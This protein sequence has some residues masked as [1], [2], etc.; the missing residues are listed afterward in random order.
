MSDDNVI[1]QDGATACRL[2][3]PYSRIRLP[4]YYSLFPRPVDRKSNA[5]PVRYRATPERKVSKKYAMAFRHRGLRST[6]QKGQMSRSH[7]NK[8]LKSVWV[9]STALHHRAL[10]TFTRR[11]DHVLLTPR[12]VW[13]YIKCL[14]TYLLNIAMD[15]RKYSGVWLHTFIVE[16]EPYR[17][18]S[19]TRYG[20]W[21]LSWCVN[22]ATVSVYRRTIASAHTCTVQWLLC[23]ARPL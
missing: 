5:L 23:R 1:I 3:T 16:N 12:P 2:I 13:C 22:T 9:P 15:G 17:F 14:L 11:R 20:P 6:C 21:R 18:D 10:W 7:P 19:V 8:Q 4:T